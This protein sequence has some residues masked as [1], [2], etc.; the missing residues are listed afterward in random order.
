MDIE[1]IVSQC[2]VCEETSPALPSKKLQVHKVVGEPWEKVGMDLFMSK[3]RGCL[4]IVDHLMDLFEISELPDTSDSGS[5]AA[6][7][8]ARHTV[9]VHS[10]G[11]A[12]FS[13]REF[14]FFCQ[15]W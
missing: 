13:A 10:N 9:W 6:V 5:K 12:Q 4:V 1:L 11:G 3:G 8:L 7:Y 15:T 2:P 14:S